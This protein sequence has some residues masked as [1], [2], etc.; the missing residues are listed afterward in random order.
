MIVTDTLDLVVNSKDSTKTYEYSLE[1]ENGKIVNIRNIY[2]FSVDKNSGV[3]E[4]FHKK[5]KN[6]VYNS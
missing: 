1:I 3:W 6:G 4:D 2:G 5:Y